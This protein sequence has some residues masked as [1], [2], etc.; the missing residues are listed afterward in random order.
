MPCYQALRARLDS[1]AG[2]SSRAPSL[3]GTP[4]SP[5][6]TPTQ[7]DSYHALLIWPPPTLFARLFLSIFFFFGGGLT[8]SGGRRVNAFQKV[9]RSY[10][11]TC[12]VRVTRGDDEGAA[13]DL[14]PPPPTS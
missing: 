4:S 14:P 1:L 5:I 13:C 12:F 6:C 8:T 7:P 3:I 2:S 10:G 11:L 9:V